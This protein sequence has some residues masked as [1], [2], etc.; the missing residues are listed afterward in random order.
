MSF[1]STLSL[2][3][4]YAFAKRLP[5][6][7]DWR[8]PTVRLRTFLCK[9]IFKHCGHAVNIQQ[10]V[11]FGKGANIS[12]GDYSGIGQGS[13]IG[14][15][16][17]EVIIGDHVLIGPELVIYT[18]SH[19]YEDSTKLIQQQGGFDK[20]VVIGNDVWIGSRVT[21]MPGVTIHDGAVIGAG[22]IVTKDVPPYAAVG[23][24]PAKVLKFRKPL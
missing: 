18:H 16:V 1:S 3:L 23:G 13:N 10:N 12:I 4:Y 11:Y 15:P 14:N 24:V 22:A 19:N 5:G 21:I 8:F 6:R 17:A 9:H 20:P 2:V 7:N